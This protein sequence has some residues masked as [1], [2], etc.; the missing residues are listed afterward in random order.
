MIKEAIEDYKRHAADR[1]I[2]RRPVTTIGANGLP[3]I[4]PSS[5]LVVGDFVVVQQNQEI[6]ADCVV[7]ATSDSEGV[8]YIETA[9]L[10]GETNLKR[11]FPFRATEKLAH[12]GFASVTGSVL[13]SSPS[14]HLDEFSGATCFFAVN[15]LLLLLTLFVCPFC[16]FLCRCGGTGRVWQASACG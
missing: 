1:A 12:E 4:V 16:V 8:C 15:P 14:F 9:Q 3:R 13:C 2:N 10:D 5:D 7:M 6:P 11:R